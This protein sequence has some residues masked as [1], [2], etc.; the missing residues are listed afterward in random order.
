MMNKKSYKE[1]QE[2]EEEEFKMEQPPQNIF[3]Q[4][5]IKNLDEVDDTESKGS[6]MHVQY[7]HADQPKK[8]LIHS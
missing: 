1:D 6:L 7:Y 4:Q 2:P 3:Q 5:Q 8:D